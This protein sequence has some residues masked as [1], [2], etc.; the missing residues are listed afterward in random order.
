MFHIS[1]DS[2]EITRVF[3]KL[4]SIINQK[5]QELK[6]SLENS[7]KQM[8]SYCSSKITGIQDKLWF[9]E[10]YSSLCTWSTSESHINIIKYLKEC[11]N[12][13][14][15][16]INA[17]NPVDWIQDAPNFKLNLFEEI[18]SICKQIINEVK[19][20]KYDK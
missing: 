17:K 8:N 13:E 14:Q 7:N 2:N 6:E 16:L 5:E 11:K 4:R 15:L 3:E 10:S 1:I 12:R 18:Q 20:F 19:D 9:I